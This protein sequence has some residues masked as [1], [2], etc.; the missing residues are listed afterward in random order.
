MLSVSAIKAQ[1]EIYKSEEL[2]ILTL[3]IPPMYM[4]A[5]PSMAAILAMLCPKI[6]RPHYFATRRRPR[7][8]ISID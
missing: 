8:R 7:L 4:N 5:P 3:Q 2:I 1:I 6:Q